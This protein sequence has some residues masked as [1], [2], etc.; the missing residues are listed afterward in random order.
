MFALERASSPTAHA[1][2][3]FRLLAHPSA[4]IFISPG[5]WSRGSDDHFKSG[6]PPLFLSPAARGYKEAIASPSWIIS[7]LLTSFTSLLVASSPY[8]HHADSPRSNWVLLS[9]EEEQILDEEEAHDEVTH[10]DS[11]LLASQNAR[12]S[13]GYPGW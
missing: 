11:T 4:W 3:K 2:E 6:L 7:L 13:L 9:E 1:K 12:A 10:K 8:P 5:K